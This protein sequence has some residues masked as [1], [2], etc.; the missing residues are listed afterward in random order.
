[1]IYLSDI[2]KNQREEKYMIYPFVTAG[3]KNTDFPGFDNTALQAAVDSVAGGG[4]VVLS[5]GVYEMSDALRM[6]SG[7][8]L[9]GQGEQTVLFKTPSVESDVIRYMGVGH[10]EVA[11]KNPERFKPGMGVHIY[12]SHAG[13]FYSTVATIISI[14]GNC[15]NLSRALCSDIS[16]KS[17][18]KAV[19]VFPIIEGYGIA[20]AC[21][22]ELV[23][24]GNR[25]NNAYING[26]RGAGVFLV[27]SDR[28]TMRALTVR[29]FNGDA[30][31]FQH[32][33][34]CIAQNNICENN[35][36][37]GLHPGGGSVAPLLTGNKC[38]NN[39]GD[40]IFYCLRVTY[41][42]C[43]NNICANNGRNGISIGHR[44]NNLHIRGNTFENNRE[45]GVYYRS[46]DT[47][48]TGVSVIFENNIIRGNS[49]GDSGSQVNFGT[50]A[51]NVCF[52]GNTIEAQP[53]QN[54]VSGRGEPVSLYFD[55]NDIDGNVALRG[56]GLQYKR[57]EV[58]PKAGCE[59]AKPEHAR[60][61]GRPGRTAF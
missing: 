39:D 51:Q 4:E 17:G 59:A 3:D 60:H 42:T 54:A 6:R 35:S 2:T 16:H 21:V 24:D 28:V 48:D 31:S 9:R 61:L 13:G 5:A 32:G 36:G 22:S 49:G 15:L 53:G 12:D 18:G 8:L 14:E 44:D 55:G 10:F 1:M 29:N 34:G 58:L 7:V 25:K 11:V 56:D 26:C 27:Q 23:I 41:S 43:E 47:G 37:S 50:A 33:V 30:L 20:D 38:I 57:P 46:D 40:G 52:F 45:T 19:S